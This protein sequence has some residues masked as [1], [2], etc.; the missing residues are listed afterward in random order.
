MP[1]VLARRFI[2]IVEITP[3]KIT[4]NSKRSRNHG[5]E[6]SERVVGE[7]QKA[8]YP[9]VNGQHER[10]CESPSSFMNILTWSY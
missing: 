1:H 3:A 4:T 7:P 5:K 2:H 8:V 6:D 10:S 9:R